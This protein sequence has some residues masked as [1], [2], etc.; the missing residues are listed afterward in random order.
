MC[1]YATIYLFFLFFNQH[2]NN[3]HYLIIDHINFLVRCVLEFL[4]TAIGAEASQR[5]YLLPFFLLLTNCF[6]KELCQVIIPPAVYTI[7]Y[8]L[9]S[10][11][12]EK[13]RLLNFS[14]QK[15]ISPYI[16]CISWNSVELNLFVGLLA[17]LLPY[18]IICLFFCF[19]WQFSTKLSILFS[20]ICYLKINYWYLP[21]NDYLLSVDL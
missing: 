13:F 11:S 2:L 18:S 12:V 16:I 15:N 3:F 19:A 5:L 8:F 7:S 17:I 14:W 1:E 21:I 10:P 20:K 9:H 6:P 4:Y